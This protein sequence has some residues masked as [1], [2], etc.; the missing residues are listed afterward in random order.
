VET[1]LDIGRILQLATIAPS[2][3][4]NGV[5]SIYLAGENVT[6]AQTEEGYQVQLLNPEAVAKTLQHFYEPPALSRATRAP[7]TVEILNASGDPL[8]P[9]LTMEN[10]RWHGFVP[11]ISPVTLS[12]SD[13]TTVTYYADNLKSSYDW[14]ISWVMAQEDEQVIL[15]SETTS[16]Y[17]YRIVLGSDYDPCRPE[18][19]APKPFLAAQA[20]Q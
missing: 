11:T 5:Q 12:K 15:N 1:D 2:V 13:K 7:I 8:M 16:D 19:Y 9:I 14:L 17:D 10:L 6:A 4:E 3:R 18:L 20:T